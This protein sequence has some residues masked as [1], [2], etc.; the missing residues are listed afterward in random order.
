M[1]AWRNGNCCCN[2]NYVK[3]SNRVFVGWLYLTG[4]EPTLPRSSARCSGGGP[5]NGWGVGPGGTVS[6]TN[7]NPAAIVYPDPAN[8]L[9]PR[10]VSIGGVST[11]Y[12]SGFN[13]MTGAGYGLS[14]GGGLFAT[15]GLSLASPT[16][17]FPD[18]FFRTWAITKVASPCNPVLPALLD[19]TAGAT[20][21]TFLDER[22]DFTVA[23]A[24]SEGDFSTL[25]IRR[26]LKNVIELT[27][28]PRPFFPA[29][30]QGSVAVDLLTLLDAGQVARW[31]T[32]W[33]DY[34]NVTVHYGF[35]WWNSAKVYGEDKLRRGC[36]G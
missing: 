14:A 11:L 27:N 6:K 13:S 24:V 23:L 19:T 28:I 3:P 31:P 8:P 7:Y 26:R 17:P 5:I 10:Y 21:T 33:T 22:L 25:Q 20:P 2:D 35:S 16:G 36:C 12:A 9:D 30:V 1:G 29:V 34:Q 18:T 4:P 32:L 15:W